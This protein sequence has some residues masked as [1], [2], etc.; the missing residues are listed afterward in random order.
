MLNLIKISMISEQIRQ[1]GQLIELLAN[2]IT[3]IQQR[4]VIQL[5]ATPHC[6]P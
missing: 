2:C 5:F 1:L 3:T 4:S 6:P